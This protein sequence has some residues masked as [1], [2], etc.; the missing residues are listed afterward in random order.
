MSADAPEPES[1]TS[2]ASEEIETKH[3]SQSRK[4]KVGA[5]PPSRSS[6]RTKAAAVVD[7]DV[8]KT[9]VVPEKSTRTLHRSRTSIKQETPVVAE[10]DITKEANVKKRS[11]RAKKTPVVQDQEAIV[12]EEVQP[13]TKPKRK[14]KKQKEE[15]MPPLAARTIG[16]QLLIGAHVS[17]AGGVH[18]SIPNAL[19]VGANSFALFLKSQ[20][21]WANPPLDPTIPP[22]FTSACSHHKYDAGVHIVPHGSYLVNLAHPD[23]ARTKQAYESFVDDLSRCEKL[24]IRLYNFH[25]GNSAGAPDRASAIR[26]LAAQM[27]RAHQDPATGDVITLLETMAGGKNTLGSTFEDL[28]DIIALIEKKER[29]G[30]CLDTCHIFAAGY[31]VR[32]PDAYQSTMKRFDTIVGKE[33]LKAAHINDSKAP[34]GSARDLH[35]NIGTGFLGLRA[36]WNLVNDG[37]FHGLPLVLETPIDVPVKAELVGGGEAES[38]KKKGPVKKAKAVEDKGIWARE[39]KLLEQL[40]GMDVESREFEEMETRLA[41]EGAAERDRVEDQVRRRDD[42]AAKKSAGTGRGRKKAAETET[43]SSLDEDELD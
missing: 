33:Y 1:I 9:S 5:E 21:K 2:V 40:R 11:S 25:P 24:G 36:F 7:I 19:H 35:A 30:V 34:L 16:S 13:I 18:N 10:A 6:K 29:V 23:P 37:R 41:A 26:H 39:I 15:E 38:G 4:R 28:R 20:R 43:E 42:K 31:D 22:L 17:G 3:S 32:T 14:T 12:D 8:K 27:N